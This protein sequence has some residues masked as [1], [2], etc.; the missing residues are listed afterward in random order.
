MTRRLDQGVPGHGG[1]GN[2][3]RAALRRGGNTAAAI[4]TTSGSFSSP[5]DGVA[6]FWRRS[7]VRKGSSLIGGLSLRRSSLQRT[8]S[9]TITYEVVAASLPSWAGLKSRGWEALHAVT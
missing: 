2:L 3:V 8:P 7:D 4:F 6:A 5:N 1:G 9:Q